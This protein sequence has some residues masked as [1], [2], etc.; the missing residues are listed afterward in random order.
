M[1]MRLFIF[2]LISFTLNLNIIAQSESTKEI[3]QYNK[4]GQKEGL[5]KDTI[6]NRLRETYFKN[7]IKSGIYK[8]YNLKKELLIFGEYC[9]GKM[10]GTWY[11]FGNTGHIW[12]IFKDFTKNTYSIINEGDKKKYIPDYKCYSISYYPN[13]N[14]R[15]EGTLL[16]SEGESPES[17]SS[18]EYG[19]WKYYNNTGKLIKTRTFK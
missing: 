13:G 2:I 9:K 17:D 16:W 15:D 3:N 5:W 7:G 6:N 18:V 19:E 8:Q 14:I 4:K 11:F 1:R 12:T 10:C